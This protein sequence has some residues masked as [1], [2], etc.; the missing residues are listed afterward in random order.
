MAVPPVKRSHNDLSHSQSHRAL[1]LME[2]VKFH[3]F[4]TVADRNY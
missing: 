2:P 3:L 1:L 4:A